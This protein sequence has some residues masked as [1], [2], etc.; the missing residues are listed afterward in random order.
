MF[1]VGDRKPITL[2]NTTEGYSYSCTKAEAA[3]HLNISKSTFYRKFPLNTKISRYKDFLI[4]FDA[5]FYLEAKMA[6]RKRKKGTY[7]DYRKNQYQNAY[8]RAV[9]F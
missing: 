2:V 3:R 7:N 6:L 4:V 8:K 9:S 5:R 1:Y